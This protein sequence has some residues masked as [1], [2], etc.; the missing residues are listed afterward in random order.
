MP[1]ILFNNPSFTDIKM[2]APIAEPKIAATDNGKT[3]F[4]TT[5]LAFKNCQ[6]PPILQKKEPIEYVD[7]A[8]CGGTPKKI[9][10][11]REIR[12]IP[13]L[14]KLPTKLATKP[15]RNRINKKK[16]C[17]I[18]YVAPKLY[19]RS[20]SVLIRRDNSRTFTIQIVD[21]MEDSKN[22]SSH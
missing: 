3:N 6:N 2:R 19:F 21:L 17:S 11:D 8:N 1:A 9:I 18:K 20:D 16:I 5:F 12:E 22:M 14:T 7:I 15:I 10:E 13:P 4:H